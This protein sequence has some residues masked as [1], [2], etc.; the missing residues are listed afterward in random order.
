ML[1]ARNLARSLQIQTA[2]L[3]CGLTRLQLF[4]TSG[5]VTPDADTTTGAPG[6]GSGAAAADPKTLGGAGGP[7]AGSGAAAEQ[8][9]KLTPS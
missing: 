6:T 8:A 3:S 1:A 4:S 7:G 5:E 9:C 2:Q